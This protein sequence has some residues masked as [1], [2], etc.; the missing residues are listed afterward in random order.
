M[1]GIESLSANM[2]QF[3]VYVY[4]CV[5]FLTLLSDSVCCWHQWVQQM[6][7]SLAPLPGEP[8]LS[9][10]AW[11]LHSKNG[12]MYQWIHRFV[13]NLLFACLVC[14][15]LHAATDLHGALV[16]GPDNIMMLK[17]RV[18]SLTFPTLKSP[19]KERKSTSVFNFLSALS[20]T[21]RGQEES[22]QQKVPRVHLL[23]AA[24]TAL[25]A[26]QEHDGMATQLTNR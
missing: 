1:P 21:P 2:L 13:S 8:C 9:P 5:S 17:C 19:P 18:P 24:P 23:H 10:S 16:I 12:Y 11:T 4:S 15:K 20:L 25:Q 26:A 6:Q 7:M 14:T 22:A 3:R